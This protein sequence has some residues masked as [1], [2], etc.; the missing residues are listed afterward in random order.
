MKVRIFGMEYRVE[1]FS[2]HDP[3][4]SAMGRAIMSR[5]LIRLS[6]SMPK[7]VE[8]ETLLH[9]VV[10]LVADQAGVALTEPQV[11]VISLGLYT[12]GVRV[13]VEE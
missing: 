8:E 6:D 10:H 4:D 9:E 7:D 3:T 2:Q 11:A 13:P 12:A 5:G 1:R